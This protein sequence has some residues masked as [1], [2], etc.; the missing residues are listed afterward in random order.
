V[1]ARRW[2]C[3]GSRVRGPASAAAIAGRKG[4]SKALSNPGSRACA[5]H[6]LCASL[7]SRRCM[8]IQSEMLMFEETAILR[9]ISYCLLCF[10][11]CLCYRWQTSPLLLV[12]RPKHHLHEEKQLRR[13]PPRAVPPLG[14]LGGHRQ[15][16]RGAQG[17]CGRG[18]T[19][20]KL[21][22]VRA[23]LDRRLQ[24]QHQQRTRGRNGSAPVGLLGRPNPPFHQY[25][26][27]YLDVTVLFCM[28]SCFA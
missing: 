20:E 1:G 10:H 18:S 11:M 19:E 12:P 22:E 9:R 3:Y 26:A 25:H 15:L 28:S 21:R 4:G 23:E 27:L 17:Q 8:R 16:R 6:S 2:R 14:T 5:H 13:S 7:S 24:E